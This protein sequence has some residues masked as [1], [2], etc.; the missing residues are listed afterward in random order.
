MSLVAR[1]S[2]QF[3]FLL[4]FVATG[5][6]DAWARDQVFDSHEFILENGLQLVVVESHSAPVVVHMVWYKVG[7]IDEFAGKSGLAHFLEH[8]MFKGST[9]VLAGEFSRTVSNLGGIDNAFTAAD[10]TAYYQKMPVDKLAIVM[11]MEADRMD[12]L[13]IAE[14]E[15]ANERDVVIEERLQRVDNSAGALFYEKLLGT[16]FDEHPYQVPIIGWPEDLETLTRDDALGFYRSFYGPNNAVVVVVGDVDPD[17]V[18]TLADKFYGGIDPVD[19][20]IRHHAAEPPHDAPRSFV[21]EDDRVRQASWSRLYIAP[22]DNVGE[23]QFVDALTVLDGI[24]GGGLL[25]RLYQSLVV[26]QGIAVSASSF[27]SSQAIGPGKFRI[28]V[29]P[30]EGKVDDIAAAVDAVLA[31]LLENG[32][33]EKELYRV[34]KSLLAEVI[35]AQDSIVSV[36]RIFG[37]ALT[38]GQSIADI[39][40]WAGRIEAVTAKDVLEAAHSVFNLDQSVTGI[41]QPPDPEQAQAGDGF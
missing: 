40:A 31:E 37:S 35:Y 13:V 19:I 33:T 5:P 7:A 36:A 32:A 10:Y 23:T 12:G 18:K 28:S 2:A 27:Y 17:N 22:S 25:G 26:E 39:E 24:V 14:D 3:L 38:T 16:L 20:A 34:K 11:K 29:V 41:L 9:N 8:L 1:A 15:V 21:M 30:E 6:G 4:I